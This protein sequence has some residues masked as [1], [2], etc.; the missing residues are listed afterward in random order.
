M[1]LKPIETID[2]IKKGDTIIINSSRFKNEPFKVKAVK[3][4]AIDGTEIIID[5]K[6]NQFFNVGLYLQ[7]KSWVREC[8]IVT[9]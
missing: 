8:C 1:K 6:M 5:R 9:D 3:V 7:G 2:D 4:S